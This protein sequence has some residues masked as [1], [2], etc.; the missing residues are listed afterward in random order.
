[1]KKLIKKYLPKIIGI[2][3]NSLYRISKKKA[4]IKVYRIFCTPRGGKVKPHQELF[5]RNAKATKVNYGRIQLQIYHW[6]SDGP[7]VLLVHGWDSNSAR[8]SDLVEMLVKE[9]YN[10]IAFDSPAQGNSGGK[11]LHAPLYAKCVGKMI[12]LYKPKYL[13]GH[14]MGGMAIFFNEHQKKSDSVEKIVSLGTPTEMKRIMDGLQK[15]LGL[16]ADL[17]KDVEDYFIQKFNYRFVDFNTR[18]FVQSLHQECLVIHDEF[19]KIVPFEDGEAL[20]QE[21]SNVRFIKTEGAGHSL[22][23]EYINQHVLDFLA[24]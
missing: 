8:W 18:N 1:M 20:Q 11:I 16:K 13:I 24:E 5:L 3:L 4:V 6:K 7:T 12:K 22:N 10:I 21:I 2:Q 15:I 14:S 23:R 19:D 9:N 17:M